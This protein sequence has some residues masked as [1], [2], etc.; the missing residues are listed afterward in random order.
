[1][2]SER[3]TEERKRAGRGEDLP[4]NEDDFA[5]DAA[6]ALQGLYAFSGN[7]IRAKEIVDRWMVL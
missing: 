1:M 6:F 7:M 5:V 4:D 3:L 2:L